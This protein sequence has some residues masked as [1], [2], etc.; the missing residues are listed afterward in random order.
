MLPTSVG[1]ETATSWSPVG[2]RIQLSHRG[3]RKSDDNFM[4]DQEGH[5]K[6]Q[7]Q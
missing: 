1:V 5:L 6:T 2:R 3:Q 7:G 4:S